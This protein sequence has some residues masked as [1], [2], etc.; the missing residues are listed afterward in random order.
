M[1]AMRL[2][3]E[4]FTQKR[5]NNAFCNEYVDSNHLFG[6]LEDATLTDLL[7]SIVREESTKKKKC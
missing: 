3:S 5:F 6:G 1:K 2:I 4:T 7:V